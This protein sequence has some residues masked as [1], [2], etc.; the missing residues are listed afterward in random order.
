MPSSKQMLV[1]FVG[2][3]KDLWHSRHYVVVAKVFSK[4]R[5]LEVAISEYF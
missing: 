4:A 3:G 5:F 1:A 2:I